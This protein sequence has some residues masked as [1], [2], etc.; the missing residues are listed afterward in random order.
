MVEGLPA[1]PEAWVWWWHLACDPSIRVSQEGLEFKAIL[2]YAAGLN[3]A[4]ASWHPVW[5]EN[6]YK[7]PWFLN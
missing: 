1:M 2:S 5:G 7:G 4:R 6:E 3:V